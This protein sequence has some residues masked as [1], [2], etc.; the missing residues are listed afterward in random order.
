[1]TTSAQLSLRLLDGLLETV[2][3]ELEVRGVIVDE[4]KP[5]VIRVAPAPL[6]NNFDDCV[7]FVEAFASALQECRGKG[8]L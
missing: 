4:R 2:M 3:H 6:Y 8:L 5:N 7:R 1:M